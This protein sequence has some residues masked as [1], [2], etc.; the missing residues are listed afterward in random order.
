M[1]TVESV[2]SMLS[3]IMTWPLLNAWS[4]K[5]TTPG[6]FLVFCSV[7]LVKTDLYTVEPKWKE[8]EAPAWAQ[9]PFSWGPQ[10]G[11]RACLP[12]EFHFPRKLCLKHASATTSHVYVVVSWG[13]VLLSSLPTM[14][15]GAFLSG[16]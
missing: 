12:G 15:K 5:H 8:L 6:P 3:V 2:L 13:G 4:V 7:M 1:L 9:D 10:P 16:P 14:N 11:P